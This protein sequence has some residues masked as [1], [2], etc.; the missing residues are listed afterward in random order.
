MLEDVLG[1]NGFVVNSYEDRLIPADK[2]DLYEPPVLNISMPYPNVFSIDREIEVCFPRTG[3][4]YHVVYSHIF[5]SVFHNSYIRK[6]TDNE[7]LLKR[8]K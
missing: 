2:T 7:D 3:E 4:M 6:P 8:M 1:Q 5:S